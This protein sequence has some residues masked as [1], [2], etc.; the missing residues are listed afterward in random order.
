[1]AAALN[2]PRSIVLALALLGCTRA[3][4]RGSDP[5]PVEHA[6]VPST[7]E[8]AA[9]P[10]TIVEPPPAVVE[11][12]ALDLLQASV[13]PLHEGR[14]LLTTAAEPEWA[15]GPVLFHDPNSY[16]EKWQLERAAQLDAL[17]PQLRAFAGMTVDLYGPAGRKCT[18]PLERLTIEA[19]LPM[20]D[21][22]GYEA[23]PDEAALWDFL[24]K[25]ES[26]QQVVSLVASFA[27][28]PSCEGALWAR[29]ASLPAPKL[30]VLGDQRDHAALLADEHRRAL[31]SEA[32][33]QFERDYRGYAAD[34]EFAEDAE[35]WASVAKG[36]RQVWV[37]EQGAAQ[38]VSLDFGSHEFAPCRWQ[39]PVLG[40]ARQLQ[41]SLELPVDGRPAPVAV[42]DADL[43]GNYELLILEDGGDF[44]NIRV[45]SSTPTLQLELV[46]PDNSHVWC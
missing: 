45:L 13:L 39:G 6:N 29:D 17:P 36:R 31:A 27:E 43:D 26:G 41:P 11:P 40:A 15:T 44:T 35:P 46:L 28:D 3:P 22:G 32:G 12:P 2:S 25:A 30:L 5:P 16:H 24:L 14:V 38:I 18:V 4:D 23:R 7:A 8:P 33:Q 10:A 21:A 37:D 9:P 20:E 1:M 42:F 19:H 34:P